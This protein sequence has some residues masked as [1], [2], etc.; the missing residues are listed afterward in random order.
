MLIGKKAAAVEALYAVLHF[1]RRAECDADVTD[2]L[3]I[4]I[5]PAAFG[6]VEMN[7][8]GGADELFAE[9]LS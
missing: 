7:R 4:R 9:T 3:R 5:E 8:V 2:Q 6:D 1:I